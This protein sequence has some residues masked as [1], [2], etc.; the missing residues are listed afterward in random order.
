MKLSRSIEMSITRAEF[1]RALPAAVNRDPFVDEGDA[2]VHRQGERRWRIGFNPLPEFHMGP[3]RLER[4]RIDFGFE[5]Y[6]EAEIAE[7]LA[8]FELH[9]RRGGG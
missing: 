4:H 3:V 2:F 9:F 8:R 6:S 5:G 1:L 7:F